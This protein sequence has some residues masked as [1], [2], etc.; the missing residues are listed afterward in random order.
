[1]AVVGWCDEGGDAW[2]KAVTLRDGEPPFRL[3]VFPTPD[4]F[5]WE[6]PWSWE[7]T[8]SYEGND[9]A[10]VEIDA[11]VAPSREAAMVAAFTEATAHVAGLADE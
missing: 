3:R 10:A 6:D 2:S 8:E 5:A 11:G 9:E 7:I 1:M 4:A